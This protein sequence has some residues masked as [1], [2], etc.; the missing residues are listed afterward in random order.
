M[1][2]KKKKR[3][4]HKSPKS[5]GNIKNSSSCVALDREKPKKT[6]NPI[7][8]RPKKAKRGKPDPTNNLN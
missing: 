5:S 8:I 1:E 2:I 7:N 3:G 6:E 4:D